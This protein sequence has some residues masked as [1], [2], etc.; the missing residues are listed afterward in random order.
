LKYLCPVL[1]PAI[2][3]NHPSDIA[4]VTDHTVLTDPGRGRNMTEAPNLR[5]FADA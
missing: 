3:A 1:N 2:V 5:T 4:A